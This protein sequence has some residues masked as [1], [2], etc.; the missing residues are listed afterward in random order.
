[1]SSVSQCHALTKQLKILFE[2]TDERDSQIESIGALLEKR[3]Q[4]LPTIAPPFS[5]EEQSMGEEMIYW[6]KE[7]DQELERLKFAIKRD[8]NNVYKTKTTVQKYTNPYESVQTDGMFYDKR[9]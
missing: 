2:G 7:I 1:M 3:E 9:N 8:M 6:N 5:P 4:L